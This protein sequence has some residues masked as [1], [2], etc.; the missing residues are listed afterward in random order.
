M[1]TT[2]DLPDEL[3][4]RA[5]ILAAQRRTTLKELVLTGLQTVLDADA[6][7]VS[8]DEAVARLR[9]GLHL[10]GQPLSREESHARRQIS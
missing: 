10:G 9:A 1:K 2:L 7:S 3:L 8:R 6:S 4:H 5:K